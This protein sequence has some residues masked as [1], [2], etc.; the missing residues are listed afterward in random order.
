MK[1]RSLGQTGFERT[2]KPTRRQRFLAEMDAVIPWA[3]LVALVTPAQP[4]PGPKGGRVPFPVETMLSSAE[5]GHPL[6]ARLQER[7]VD[8][9]RA[10]RAYL[11]F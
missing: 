4:A 6:A 1:Q 11:S 5:R 8:L 3:R 2:S 10:P 7:A 9:R